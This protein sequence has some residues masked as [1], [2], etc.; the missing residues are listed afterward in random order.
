MDLCNNNVDI[1]FSAYD[2]FLEYV[3]IQKIGNPHNLNIFVSKKSKS[4]KRVL[5][6]D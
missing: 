5:I 6:N 2:V 4:P 1:Q 3:H